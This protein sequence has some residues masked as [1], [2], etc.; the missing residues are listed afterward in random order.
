MQTLIEWSYFGLFIATFLAGS[1]LPFSSE[2]VLSGLLA[3]GAK[4][5]G[6]L[7]A[8][9]AGNFLGGMSCY[10][11]GH[12]GKIE[13]IEKYLGV[14]DEKMQKGIRFLH[15][16]GAFMAFFT[17]IPIVGDLLAVSL[18]YMRANIWITSVSMLLGKFVRYIL[19][20]YVTFGVINILK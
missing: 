7:L 1:I 16:K 3:V 6:C 2:I 14:S 15:G 5:T 18:G 17:F 4:S 13:W 9:T 8:A 10:Y 20:I 11:L 19:W 12:L